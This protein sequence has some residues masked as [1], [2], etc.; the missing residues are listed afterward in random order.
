MIVV[1]DIYYA[2]VTG[3]VWGAALVNRYQNIGSATITVTSELS[4][5]LPKQSTS[6]L[7]SSRPIHTRP[8]RIPVW[9]QGT[10]HH[11]P[12]DRWWRVSSGWAHCQISKLSLQIRKTIT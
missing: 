5:S 8:K 4:S 11:D 3:M 12:P 9:S 6:I 2:L 10:D 1:T 7:T